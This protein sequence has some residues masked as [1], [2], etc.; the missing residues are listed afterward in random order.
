MPPIL[1]T[2]LAQP[3][4]ISNVQSAAHVSYW[5]TEGGLRSHPFEETNSWRKKLAFFMD[6]ADVQ[7]METVHP[8]NNDP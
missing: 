4:D 5:I 8:S 2:G 1:W 6:Q 7:Q 3:E